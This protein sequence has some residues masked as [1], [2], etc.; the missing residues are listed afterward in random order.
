VFLA[1]MF[2][3]E[4][5]ARPAALVSLAALTAL[6]VGLIAYEALHFSELRVR[7]RHLDPIE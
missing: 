2:A 3:G 4:L 5:A 7:L 1:A 6:L